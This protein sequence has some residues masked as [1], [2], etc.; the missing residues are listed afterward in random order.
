MK[1]MTKEQPDVGIL[2]FHCSDNFGAMLQAYGMKIYLCGSGIRAEIVCYE[3]PYMTGR[4]W[5]APYIPVSGSLKKKFI[6]T[7]NGWKNHRRMGKDFFRLRANMRRF[8]R[9]YLVKGGFRRILFSGRL[10]YLRY[11]CYIV[12]SDQI[13]NPDITCGFRKPYF[14]AF[15]NR[16]KKKVV[17]YAA[18]I[19]GAVLPDRYDE[20][21]SELLKHVD[22]VSV[23]E[24]GAIPYIK[25]FYGGNVCAVMDPV[26]F[27]KK[28][29]WEQIENP[30]K[31]EGYILVYTTETNLGLV[32]Y[33]KALSADKGLPVIEL[34]VK[35]G[36]SETGF[37]MEYTAGPA[38]FLGYIHKAEYVI[39]S[40]FHMIAFSILYEKQ[41]LVFAHSHLGERTQNLLHVH[42]LE[43]R[44]YQEDGSSDI[45]D[46]IDWHEV[47]R[48][49]EKQVQA[50]EDF[51]KCNIP[52]LRKQGE[53][54]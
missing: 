2:T 24:E 33:V 13:W 17:A 34:R 19:G 29:E 52:D 11:P 6:F 12:G 7:V 45:D 48:R 37:H 36:N 16:W 23:R 25:R 50:S 43:D 21:F 31:Q 40:S 46:P 26:F 28:R 53:T 1:R 20:E 22:A 27:L 8:R 14:G 3:P 9:Q 51:L 49:T 10:R 38:E 4:H 47:K 35:A 15:E 30:P 39:T 54:G 41:F 18:S 44:M 32:E 42:G 5:W